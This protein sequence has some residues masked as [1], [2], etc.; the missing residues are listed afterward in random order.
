MAEGVN[1][2]A[3]RH[4]GV[5]IRPRTV[6][7]CLALIVVAVLCS[8]RVASDASP[9]RAEMVARVAEGDRG[10]P[11]DAL[12]SDAGLEPEPPGLEPL[13]FDAGVPPRPHDAG[14]PLPLAWSVR[15]R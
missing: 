1:H 11:R 10:R 9:G 14:A 7:F 3:V 15:E 13:P 6:L 2:A 12:R 8:T 5:S 4:G